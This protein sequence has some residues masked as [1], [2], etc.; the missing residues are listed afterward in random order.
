MNS[1]Q[2]RRGRRVR[3]THSAAAAEPLSRALWDQSQWCSETFKS[4]TC[5]YHDSRWYF[6]RQQD[7]TMFLIRW[8]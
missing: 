2:R 4:E 7:L 5:V 1:S 3:L 8:S 6:K